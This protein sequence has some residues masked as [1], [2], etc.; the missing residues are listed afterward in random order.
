MTLD[1]WRCVIT[2][3]PRTKAYVAGMDAGYAAP[4]AYDPKC[5]YQPA[6]PRSDEWHA[7]WRHGRWLR[8]DEYR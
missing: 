3:R 1:H 7:G 6:D 5:P 8:M 4:Y 2:E